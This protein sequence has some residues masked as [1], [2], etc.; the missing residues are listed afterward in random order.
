MPSV[1]PLFRPENVDFM[2]VAS[3]ICASPVQRGAVR[4]F[5]V[6]AEGEAGWLAKNVI[7]HALTAVLTA[8][9]RGSLPGSLR[10]SPPARGTAA[11]SSQGL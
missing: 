7:N 4:A 9:L 8:W 6:Q 2:A 3:F 11:Q 10:K 5:H 1:V